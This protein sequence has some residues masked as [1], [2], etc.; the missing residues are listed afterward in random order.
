MKKTFMVFKALD[1]FYEIFSTFCHFDHINRTLFIHTLTYA[2]GG[3]SA[4]SPVNMVTSVSI[5]V[6]SRVTLPGIASSPSQK[7]NQESITTSEDGAKVW[8]R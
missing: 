6:T 5:Q 7:L 4:L 3:M 2:T 1:F 8:I